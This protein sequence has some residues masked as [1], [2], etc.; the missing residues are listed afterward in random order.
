M[1]FVYII[2]IGVLILAF[3]GV[4]DTLPFKY[5]KRGCMGK[6]WKLAF[7]DS[8]KGNIREFLVMFTDSF[9][10]SP[11]DKLQFSPNDKVLEIYREL[12]PWKWLPDALEVETLAEEFEKRYGV[13]FTTI[14]HE[15][16]TLGELYDGARNT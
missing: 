5:R 15:N 7:P 4:S 14:W 2:G 9:A 8:S 13:K 6:S 11:D 3:T 1:E 16:L 12:Y 10:F